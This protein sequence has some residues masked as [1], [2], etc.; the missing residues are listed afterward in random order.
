M[1]KPHVYARLLKSFSFRRRSLSGRVWSLPSELCFPLLGA[2]CAPAVAVT[3]G[4]PGAGGLPVVLSALRGPGS[5][6]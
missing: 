1:E 4:V 3:C 2:V 5:L 6:Q